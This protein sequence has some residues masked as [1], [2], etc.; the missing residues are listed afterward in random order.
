MCKHVIVFDVVMYG[1]LHTDFQFVC[2]FVIML[3][4]VSIRR[5]LLKPLILPESMQKKK[6]NKLQN[7]KHNTKSM[8]F[9]PIFFF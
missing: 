1:L 9:S 4:L 5:Y 2:L 6:T 8:N 3:L 7:T